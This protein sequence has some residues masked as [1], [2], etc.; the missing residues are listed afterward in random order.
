MTGPPLTRLCVVCFL[1]ISGADASSRLA[2][3]ALEKPIGKGSSAGEL[4]TLLLV[5]FTIFLVFSLFFVLLGFYPVYLALFLLP[6]TGG[7]RTR[8]RV[9]REASLASAFAILSAAAKGR[10]EGVAAEGVASKPVATKAAA[11]AYLKVDRASRK[12]PA[13]APKS[14]RSGTQGQR[15]AAVSSMMVGDLSESLPSKSLRSALTVKSPPSL[16]S[17][18]EPVESSDGSLADNELSTDEL[19]DADLLSS[20]TLERDD[21]LAMLAEAA[22][23]HASHVWMQSQVGPSH[24]MNSEGASAGESQAKVSTPQIPTGDADKVRPDDHF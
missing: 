17:E 12:Q 3:T 4:A 1:R 9:R 21:S 7:P 10:L 11:A 20:S 8:A 14:A 15:L 24:P 6:W 19:S 5:S 13:A 23:Q 18:A 2:A 22:L 16:T